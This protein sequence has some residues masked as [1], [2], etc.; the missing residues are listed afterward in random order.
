M[1]FSSKPPVADHP[2]RRSHW[3]IPE[4]K[5]LG[6]KAQFRCVGAFGLLVV[7]AFFWPLSDGL[8]GP[9]MLISLGIYSFALGIAYFAFGR[10]YPHAAI[11]WC[12]IVTMFRLSLVSVLV[13]WLFTPPVGIW[14]VF[15][16]ATLAFALDGLDGWLARR[17]GYV[18][19]FGA[20]FDMEVDSVLA[21]ALALHAY[22]Y[23]DVSAFVILLGLPRYIFHVAQTQMPWLARDLPPR[24]SRKVVCVLQISALIALQLP[25]MRAP[26]S[27]LV[28]GVAAIALIWSFWLDVRLLW[29]VR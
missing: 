2:P 5:G 27:D 19:D 14:S 10:T 21:L 17:E 23:G 25:M 24:F 11:G 1:V 16:V 7:A 13:A 9:G 8:A 18:S 22:L 15:A 12:N 3:P 6:P 26:L 20:R 4:I 29:R 28:A